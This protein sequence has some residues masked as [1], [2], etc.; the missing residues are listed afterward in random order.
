VFRTLAAAALLVTSTALASSSAYAADKP[1]TTP[2]QR[3]NALVA[4]SIVYIQTTWKA[5]IGDESDN[6]WVGG[7]TNGKVFTLTSGC[8]GFAL[9]ED[10]YIGT[11][12]H[13]LL[14]KIPEL[15]YDLR[16]DM[17]NEGVAHVK[18]T[19]GKEYSIPVIK[20]HADAYF[21]LY[22]L[23]GDGEKKTRIRYPNRSITVSW[24]ANVSGIKTDEARPA[25]VAGTQTFTNGD[26]AIIKVN[27]D[28][29]NALPVP[30]DDVDVQTGM[31]VATVGYPAAVDATVD[32]DYTP[33]VKTGT[34][35]ALK[36]SGGGLTD[37]YEV[38]ADVFPG[39]SGGPAV[40]QD[41][42]VIGVNSFGSG[43]ERRIS[44]IQPIEHVKELTNGAGID[45]KLGPT[46]QKYR[47][48]LDAYFDGDKTVAVKNL[49][50]VVDEQPANGL[51]KEY[52]EKAKDLPNPPPPEEGVS[53]TVLLIG[54]ALLLLAL[55]GGVAFLLLRR[56]S[57]PST[58]P[59]AATYAP[60]PGGEAGAPTEG[61]YP[62]PVTKV[63]A[64]RSADEAGAPSGPAP[65]ER[66]EVRSSTPAGFAP[67]SSGAAGQT[68]PRPSTGQPGV[69]ASPGITSVG[70][71]AALGEH[72]FCTQCGSKVTA[73]AK[74]CGECGHPV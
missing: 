55:L 5:R 47:T 43:E 17:I 37:V 53:T 20:S 36:E 48:G 62:Q 25:K 34:I 1:E 61:G 39:M 24:G 16:E 31:D 41:G 11:A 8:T 58:T 13:C 42:K 59:P 10:G 60:M 46:T 29:L 73:G 2:A 67:A 45:L 30:S 74:F 4:P 63:P 40:T 12:A 19:W 50:A 70:E 68:A 33:S 38:D 9:T 22:P 7:G 72:H 21:N 69:S 71:T 35:S 14:P 15:G 6:T 57:G 49:Q 65:R 51:A 44:F 64:P 27:E 56:R 23:T 18:Q 32:A 26:T 52:L 66:T 54:G 28:N 3:V